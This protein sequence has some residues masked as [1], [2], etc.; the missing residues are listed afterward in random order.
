[1][2]GPN[3]IAAS[4]QTGAVAITRAVRTRP[5]L[6]AVSAEGFLTRLG[7]SMISFALPL[8]ALSFGMGVTEIGLLYALRSM[9]TLLAKPA[10]GWAADRFGSKQTLV[11]AVALRCLTGC[12]FVFAT[13]PWHLYVIRV[14]HGAMT[15]AREPSAAAL[16][17]VHGDKRS[18]ASAFAW[19]ITAR[20]L[21]RAFGAAA[22]GLLIQ[23]TGSYRIVFLIAFL[24][25]CIALVTVIR[26]VKEG[27][28]VE[29]DP[30]ARPVEPAP[31]QPPMSLYRGLL[32][33]ARFGLM[34]AGSA[35]MMRG[36]FPIIAT[37]YAYLT[38]GQAGLAVS[39]SSVA[40][41]VAGPLFGWLSD[42]GSRKLALGAR[43]VAN[44]VSS[45]LYIFF[46][47]F[48][49]FLVARTMDDTG[50]AAFRPTWGAILAEVSEANPAHRAR[51][52]TYVD[53]AYTLG[54]V[55]GPMVAGLL[56]GGFGVPV[57]LGVRAA[58]SL[59]TE[60]QALRVFKKKGSMARPVALDVKLE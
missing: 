52:M 37:Q 15:A 6:V 24:T 19:Y 30:L 20:D 12:L 59:A 11:A 31:A 34:V 27:Q 29:K 8:Y 54:E 45:L 44:T 56:I 41:L 50:K 28:K 10:M 55:L 51:I 17:A 4:W 32:G 21:G 5:T 13:L 38:E 58:L 48:V 42:R 43:S 46:P 25:S 33:Y 35:E 2:T 1:V 7:F 23:A 18:M 3:R 16:I 57:M 49:G 26:Y 39:A 14:L 40:V 53:T 9:T 47:T 22:A 36:L 60:V